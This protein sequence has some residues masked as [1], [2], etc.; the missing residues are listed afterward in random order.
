MKTI[1]K[2]IKVFG[3]TLAF[4]IAAF[5]AY[6]AYENYESS[7]KMEAELSFASKTPWKWYDEYNRIQIRFI[8]ETGRSILRKVNVSQNYVIYARKNDDY[9]LE[10][11]VRFITKCKPNT[12]ITTSKKYGDGKPITLNCNE[13]G[14][15]LTYATTWRNKDTYHTWDED[16]DG[17]KFYINFRDWDFKKLDQEITL[18]K[19]K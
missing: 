1:L 13:D 17:F 12:T 16:I 2:I 10:A 4:I 6:L 8:E 11:M 5:G 18:S 7:R 14:E 3:A 9:E 15:Y 19:A